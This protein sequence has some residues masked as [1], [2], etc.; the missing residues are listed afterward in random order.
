MRSLITALVFLEAAGF[1]IFSSLHLG[2]SLGPVH[3]PVIVDATI[4]E[5]ALSVA[6]LFAGLLRLARAEIADTATIG[7]ISLAIAGV[8]V[9][10]GALAA[11]LGPR[12]E[13][14]DAYHRTALV[15]LLVTLILQIT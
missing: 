1:T 10:M 13:L 15:S 8:L 5:G 9:G 3:E 4:V 7:A 11:G 12:T 2:L 14:N 6:L